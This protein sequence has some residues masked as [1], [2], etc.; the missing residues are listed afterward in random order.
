MSPPSFGLEPSLT[1]QHTGPPPLV[2]QKAHTGLHRVEVLRSNR[3]KVS[4]RGELPWFATLLGV[5][6]TVRPR[7]AAPLAIGLRLG[8][9]LLEGRREQRGLEDLPHCRTK[10]LGPGF[11]V[12]CWGRHGFREGPGKEGGVDVECSRSGLDI[13]VNLSIFNEDYKTSPRS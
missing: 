12:G 6:P 7:R 5:P 8:V 13:A 9:E 11:G 2:T 3:K 1:L 10:V 4:Q